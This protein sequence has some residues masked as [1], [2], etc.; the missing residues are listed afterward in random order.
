M[1][2]EMSGIGEFYRSTLRQAGPRT[3]HSDHQHPINDFN[4]VSTP[5]SNSYP[6]LTAKKATVTISQ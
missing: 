4:K 2:L 1:L 5:K 3:V 6:S